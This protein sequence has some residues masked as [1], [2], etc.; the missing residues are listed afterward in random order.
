MYLMLWS[1]KK[2]GRRL[3]ISLLGDHTY[4]C[5]LFVVRITASDRG[6]FVMLFT[7]F[8]HARMRARVYWHFSS[9]RRFVCFV[10][11]FYFLCLCTRGDLTFMLEGILF[12]S[13]G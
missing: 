11:Q 7:L 4:T 13:A 2:N 10:S 5:V 1:S 3:F 8:W 9:V 12:A 6:G